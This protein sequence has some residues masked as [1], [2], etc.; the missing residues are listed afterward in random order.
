VG[1]VGLYLLLVL[2]TRYVAA[3]FPLLVMLLVSTLR[4][5]TPDCARVV[6]ALLVALFV[7]GV[8]LQCG[9]RLARAAAT[10]ISSNGDV[11]DD[12]WIVAEEFRRVGVK[13]ETPVAAI[14]QQDDDGLWP[15]AILCDWARLARVRVVGEVRN[16][17][18][19][20]SQFWRLSSNRQNEALQALRRAGARIA[21][22]TGVPAWADTTGWARIRRTDYY[23]RALD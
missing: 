8:A 22:A 4:V 15:Q 16:T 6:G 9:P 5:R 21:V 11:R 17:R 18:D 1:I 3:V 13:P 14:D 12:R 20:Q 2:Q 7:L 10:I 19:E 23:Y